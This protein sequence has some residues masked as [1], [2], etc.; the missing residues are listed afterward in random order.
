MKTVRLDTVFETEDVNYDDFLEDFKELL[1]KYE[2]SLKMYKFDELKDY[3]ELLG[4]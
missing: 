2:G 3:R 4:L 1:Y